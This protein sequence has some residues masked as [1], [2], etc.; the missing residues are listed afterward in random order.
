MLAQQMLNRIQYLHE[1]GFIHRDIKPDNFL[2]GLGRRENKVHVI[3]L[4]LAKRYRHRTTGQHIRY[5]AGKNLCGTAR[6]ASVNTHL[7]IEQSRRDDLEALGYV[8]IY[9]FKGRLPWQGIEAKTKKE[10]Y[11]AILEKK[12]STR[13][14][15]LC[16]DMP[17]EFAT[18]LTYCRSL[19]FE[20]RP[21][22]AYLRQLFRELFFREGFNQ[23]GIMKRLRFDWTTTKESESAQL[24]RNAPNP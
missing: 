13:V 23:D 11:R 7:G 17:G 20:D 12:Q 21:D 6:Y 24:A 2:M 1:K 15:D 4:G 19:G 14:E 9:F 5:R 18:Y 8:L 3:D 22:Y 10:K 16:K